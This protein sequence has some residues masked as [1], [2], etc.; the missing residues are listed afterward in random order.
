MDEFSKLYRLKLASIGPPSHY[1]GAD[2]GV[3]YS[4]AGVKCWAMSSDSYVRN[5]LRIVEGYLAAEHSKLRFKA[6]C[7][8]SSSDYKP[9]LDATP[10]WNLR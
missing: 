8:F 6:S 4:E 1:L 9:E 3:Q 7:S 10:C 2:I 5:A